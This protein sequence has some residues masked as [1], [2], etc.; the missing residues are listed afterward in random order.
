MAIL[1]PTLFWGSSVHGLGFGP[2]HLCFRVECIVSVLG[3]GV[4]RFRFRPCC[5]VYCVPS[6]AK[7]DACVQE[8]F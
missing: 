4:I 6:S 3:L 2:L 1:T 7:L 8:C 5:R